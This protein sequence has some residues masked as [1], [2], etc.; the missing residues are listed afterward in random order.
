MCSI[1]YLTQV[2]YRVTEMVEN[3]R[4]IKSL[5]RLRLLSIISDWEMRIGCPPK[6]G[7]LRW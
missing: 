2:K 1:I 7:W 4:D 5:E 6:S 3:G